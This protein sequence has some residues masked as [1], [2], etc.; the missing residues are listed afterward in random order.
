MLKI[1]TTQ[2][3]VHDHDEALAFYTGKLGML[4]RADVTMPELGNFRWLTVSPDGQ[5]DVM[6]VL[7]K[8]P[9]PPV[10]DE[11]TAAQAHELM[12]KGATGA[13]FLTTDDIYAE[14]ERLK[15]NGVEFTE[16][17]EERFYGIDCGFRDPSGNPFRLSQLTG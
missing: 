13:I 1:S 8:I 17:P 2:L 9:G 4:V 16:P 3:W 12:A 7:M 11:A 14:Y 10:F 15:A 5:D 6:I